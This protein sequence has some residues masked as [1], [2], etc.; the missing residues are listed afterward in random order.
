MWKIVLV[1]F[2]IGVWLIDSEPSITWGDVINEFKGYKGISA[3]IFWMLE[4]I[5]LFI[6]I[7]IGPALFIY[8][9]VLGG[10]NRE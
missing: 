4:A 1:W 5:F 3:P 2:L 9:C 7:M 8:D 10:D 6:G